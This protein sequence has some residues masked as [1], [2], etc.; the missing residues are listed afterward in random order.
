MET[1]NNGRTKC[2]IFT[3][4]M[5]YYRPVSNFNIGKKSE[6]YS[7]TYFCYDDNKKFIEDNK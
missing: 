6:Y 1:I 7:R 3:R 2:E 5:G 4:V